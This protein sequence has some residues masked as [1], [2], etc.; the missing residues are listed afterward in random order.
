MLA[1]TAYRQHFDLKQKVVRPMTLSADNKEKLLIN[2]AHIYD[3]MVVAYN[4]RD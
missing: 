2:R 4:L 3:Y 1:D